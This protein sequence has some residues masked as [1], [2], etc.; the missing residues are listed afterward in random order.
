MFCQKLAEKNLL[1]LSGLTHKDFCPVIVLFLILF[2]VLLVHDTFD[3]RGNQHYSIDERW[4]MAIYY[5]CS[6]LV[7]KYTY[8]LL[9][10]CALCFIV[11]IVLKNCNGICKELRTR[12]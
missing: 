8:I 4:K 1:S 9:A 2:Q 5:M 7:L 3:L 11:C 6:Y 10:V 12:T